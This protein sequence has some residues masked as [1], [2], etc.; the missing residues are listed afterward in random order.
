MM[1]DRLDGTGRY[2]EDFPIGEVFVTGGRTVTEADVVAFTGLSGDHDPL[3]T[4]EEYCRQNSIFGT[5]IAQGLLGL[6]MADGLRA[7]SGVFERTVAAGL[8]WTWRFRKPIMIGDTIH[9]EW[10]VIDKRTT[11]K[12]DRGLLVEAVTL[13]NQRSEVVA[14]GEHRKLVRRRSCQ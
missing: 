2:Y 5:R 7:R 14:E 1:S 4:D 13:V 9:V 6:V 3:H 12:A 10:K 8:E 11:S